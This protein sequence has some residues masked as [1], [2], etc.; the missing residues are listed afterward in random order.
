LQKFLLAL[1]FCNPLFHKS[2]KYSKTEASVSG[3]L[4]FLGPE[5]DFLF[6]SY[7]NSVVFIF[8]QWHTH[9][10]LTVYGILSTG[11]MIDYLS[12]QRTE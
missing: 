1:S 12:L 4:S 9:S 5:K 3:F 2:L 8:H 11:C 6:V 10:S 7:E